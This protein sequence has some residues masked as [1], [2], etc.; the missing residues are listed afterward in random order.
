MVGLLDTPSDQPSSVLFS[1]SHQKVELDIDILSRRL[2]GRTEIT[3]NPH[4]K[5]FRTVQLNC[6]QC[7]IKRVLINGKAC[8]SYTYDD[9]YAEAALR[10]DAGVEQWHMLKH[11]LEGALKERPEEELVITFPK[12]LRIE[13]QDPFTLEAQ[14]T[15][16]HKP[17]DA[18][19]RRE[20]LLPSDLDTP[21]FNRGFI[22]QGARFVPVTICVEY[23]IA[24]VRVGR[25][26]I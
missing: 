2:S 22:D 13:D 17:S 9:P 25:R 21:Q 8:S 24:E 20:S 4:T 14:K 7:E 11:K 5:E 10:W 19:S 1:V 18:S 3:I 16:A 26:E 12:S 15:T 6:R 23:V